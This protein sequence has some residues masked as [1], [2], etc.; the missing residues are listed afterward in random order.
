M[1]LADIRQ[2]V[3][4]IEFLTQRGSPSSCTVSP[5]DDKQN[6][7]IPRRQELDA[8]TLQATFLASPPRYLSAEDLALFCYTE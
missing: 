6:P 2:E 5:M 4:E 1:L 3:R 7:T 8:D